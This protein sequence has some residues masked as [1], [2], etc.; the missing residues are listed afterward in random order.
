M[1]GATV[2][3]EASP[4]PTRAR[5][6]RKAGKDFMKDPIS[7]DKLQN[8][9]NGELQKTNKHNT[10]YTIAYFE[11]FSVHKDRESLTFLSDPQDLVLVNNY[12]DP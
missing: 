5:N 10:F 12:S 7:V 9:K 4:T 11:L 3:Q 6:T 1:A 2:E 8:P